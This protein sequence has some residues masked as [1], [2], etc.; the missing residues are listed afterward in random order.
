MRQNLCRGQ[1]RE[2]VAILVV[3]TFNLQFVSSKRLSY[4]QKAENWRKLLFS[5][6]KLAEKVRKSRQQNSAEKVR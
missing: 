5:S 3:D 4:V 2:M 6:G 1:M